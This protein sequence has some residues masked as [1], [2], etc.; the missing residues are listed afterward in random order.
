MEPAAAMKSPVVE[1]EIIDA[2]RR[3]DPDAYRLLFETYK[4]RVYSI[5]LHYT[6]DET[7]ARDVTQQVF[8]KLLTRLDQFRSDAAFG[9]WLYRLVANACLDERRH[10]K[11]LVPLEPETAQARP[12]PEPSGDE[13]L[14]RREVAEHVRTAVASLQ[15]KLRIA[16]LLRYFE[17][18][19]YEEMA[20]ALGVSKGTVASR[21][22]RGHRLLADSLAH[23]KGALT[24]GGDR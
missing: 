23:L 4:D 24:L 10:A 13:R 16:V 18:L 11:R 9:T 6:A 12:S 5:A 8:V 14:L 17:G 2:C 20:E 21:L 19:S 1:D 3:G 7:A 15:P 22:N